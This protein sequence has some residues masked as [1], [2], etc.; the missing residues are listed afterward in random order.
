M[1]IVNN[2]NT[3]SVHYRGT[4]EDGT[5]FDSSHN[6]GETLTFQVGSGQMIEGFDKGV[7]GMSVGEVK[8]I[9]LDAEQAY[10]ESNPEAIQEISKAAFPED[11][12]FVIGASVQGQGPE[13]QPIIAKIVSEQ[14][15]AVTLDFNHPLAGQKLNF[16]IEMVEIES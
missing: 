12:E 11:F 2:G 1:S 9:T 7:V 10:G 8:N 4:L 14:E 3:V 13:G 15:E 16:E 6:R 5:E